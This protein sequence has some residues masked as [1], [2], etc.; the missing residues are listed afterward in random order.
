[1]S[2][3][4]PAVTA[5][6]GLLG[7]LCGPRG[8]LAGGVATVAAA[9]LI[10]GSLVA[11]EPAQAASAQPD[12]PGAALTSA[13]ATAPDPVSARIN[14]RVSG[15]RVEVLSERTSTTQLFVNPDGTV[16]SETASAPVRIKDESAKDGWRDI[17]LGLVAQPDGTFA[18]KAALTDVVVSG[19]GS[20]DELVTLTKSKNETVS[21]DWAGRLP[22]PTINGAVATYSEVAPDT[23][24]VVEATRFGFE[25]SFVIKQRP[26]DPA[27]LVLPL[28]IE[29][30]GVGAVDPNPSPTSG[31]LLQDADGDRVGMIS[32]ATTWDSSTDASGDPANVTTSELSLKQTGEGSSLRVR[33]DVAFL[34][35]PDTKYPVTV[36]PSFSVN[37]KDIV[38]DTY[39]RS[40]S[41][42]TKYASSVE[43]QV[44]TS[45]SG[46]AKSRSYVEFL[47]SKIQ[48]AKV[49][50]ATLKLYEWHS[51]SC[52]AAPL[53]LYASTNEDIGQMTWNTGQPT[54]VTSTKS[55][56][57]IAKGFSSDCDNGWITLDATPST[58]YLADDGRTKYTY[59][60]RAS[61]TSNSGW[62]KF[63]SSDGNDVPVLTVTYDRYPT[64]P[65]S[66]TSGSATSY[67]SVTYVSSSKPTLS[68]KTTDP[69]GQ[70]ARVAFEVWDGTSTSTNAKVSTCTSGYVAAGATASCTLGAALADNK[71]YYIRAQ[72]QS[73]YSSM[74]SSW[75]ALSSSAS[76]R[77]SLSAPAA[78]S[79]SCPSPYSNGSW[80]SSAPTANVS[81]TVKAATTGGTSAPSKLVVQV[82]N[83]T[84]T[85][86]TFAV[87]A[88]FTKT[89]SVSKSSGPH[90]ITATASSA[91]GTSQ[92]AQS[93][94][95]V[96]YGSAGMTAP[97]PGSTTTDLIRITASG[98][99]A[100]SA[101]ATARLEW[102]ASGTTSWTQGGSITGSAFN[103]GGGTGPVAVS[104]FAW[105]TQ[106]ATGGGINPR[107]PTLLDVRVCFDYA[108]SGVSTITKCTTDNNAAPLT[109]LRVP[110]A[111]GDGFPTAEAGE[112]QVALWTGELSLDATD[113]D[114]TALGGSLTV[115]RSHTSFADPDNVT[116]S[117]FGP[118]WTASFA[119]D[120][121]AAMQIGDS[122]TVDGTI[123]LL[124]DGE[125]PLVFRQPG[126]GVVKDKTGTYSPVGT[127]TETSGYRLALSGGGSGLRATLTQTDGSLAV[128][129]PLDPNASTVSW[130]PYSTT[131]AADHST[132]TY[133]RDAQGR[134]TRILAPVPAGV[135]CPA[136]GA[137]NPGCSALTI[138]YNPSG[139][140]APSGSSTGAYADRVAA[141]DYTTYDP[142]ATGGAMNTN[143][144]ASYAYDS[145]GRLAIVKDERLGLATTYSY[146]SYGSNTVVTRTAATGMAPFYYNYDYTNSVLRLKNVQRGPAD[147]GGTTSTLSAYVYNVPTTTS[148]LPDL[149][150]AKVAAWGQTRVPTVAFAVFGADHP[151]TTPT[152]S[153]IN[154]TDWPY[155][156]LSFTDADGYTTNSSQYGT[157]RWLTSAQFYDTDGTPTTSLDADDTAA[158]ASGQLDDPDAAKTITRYNGDIK[159]ADGTITV[160]AGSYVTDT[161]SPAVSANTGD[162][163][164]LVRVHTRYT[165][166]QG[167]PNNGINPATG[168][169]YQ[170]VT[171][172]TVGASDP[173]E[174]S[175]NPSDDLPPDLQITAVTKSGYDPIDGASATGA[176]SG[177]TLGN[178]TSTTVVMPDPA[179][180]I[181]RKTRYDAD[182]D[183]LETREPGSTGTDAG[184]TRTITYTAGTNSYDS[185]CG[186]KPQWAGLPCWSGPVAPP[187]TGVDIVD[188]RTTGYTRW[189]DP[190]GTL[191]TSGTGDSQATRTTTR[192]YLTDGRP[193]RTTITSSGITGST[194]LPATKTLYDST[195]KIPTGTANVDNSGQLTSIVTLSLD[196]W[197]RTK[198]Y[199]DVTGATT[200][201]T[202]VAPGTSGAGSIASIANSKGSTNYTYDGADATGKI[203]RRSL[204]TRLE[205]SG[206]GI[207]TGAYN[208]D[209]S[210]TTETMPA[211]LTQ[212]RTYDTIGRLTGTS[213]SGP[214]GTWLGYT[215]T[216]NS[217]GQADTDTDTTGRSA[218]YAYDRAG[219]LANVADTSTSP[220]GTASCTTRG[221]T[222]D[223]RG[224]RIRLT[225]NTSA[226]CAS[227]D[228]ALTWAYDSYSRQISGGG[229]AGPYAYDPFGRQTTIP[230]SDSASSGSADTA[231]SY[232]DNDAARTITQNGVTTTY[233][234]D[235]T[236]RR[237][238]A[239][240]GATTS[241]NSY[242]DSSDSPS[243]TA[244]SSGTISR[245]ATDL[246]GAFVAN[247]DITG[248][249]STSTLLL[250]ALTGA[251]E[252]TVTV[253]ASGDATGVTSYTT[254]DEYG[255]NGG[256]P[257]TGTNTYAW[258]GATG[259]QTSD[260]GLILMGA[261]LY[262]SATG[263]FSS[264]DAIAG[265][266]QNTYT[267]PADPI[268]WSDLTGLAPV[269]K[270]WIDQ[271]GSRINIRANI[272]EKLVL[273]HNLNP[274]IVRRLMQTYNG[275]K[276][277]EVVRG[278]VVPHNW[279]YFFRMAYVRDD[280]LSQLK[281]RLFGLAAAYTTI[282]VLVSFRP[283][284]DGLSFGIVTAYCLGSLRCPNWVN[285]TPQGR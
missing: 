239:A 116:S 229:G 77:T 23:D 247:I 224:N 42:D 132:T 48:G 50:S 134:V 235:P 98:P 153:G 135:T 226:S 100:G 165:Y 203:E 185:A 91:V 63:S 145:Q 164:Q 96:G 129:S 264:C 213:Y 188:T 94:Y 127:H 260:S 51:Y 212:V 4:R 32:P 82:D 283:A 265:A 89:V 122:T 259:R 205:V 85:T 24:L 97:K 108:S 19:G 101:T 285:R 179:D 184:T 29:G 223:S 244:S 56:L 14:A 120:T 68:A 11:A 45:N 125:D 28:S 1:M 54:I 33:P 209:G 201:T 6:L 99:P 133:S 157:G 241:T 35:D 257:M 158:A 20:D 170:L 112:G 255:R 147:S 131:E 248:S 83:A 218:I 172:T 191:E 59:A 154:A 53:D 227:G 278:K 166:D 8:R 123:A 3:R 276:G 113:V 167:A 267:Y 90:K 161:W 142:D 55:T 251:I 146:G 10:A 234:I 62:K 231:L 270:H 144:L 87:G 34:E 225:T 214:T 197:G 49:I 207:F 7:V 121:A 149:S 228:A 130:A 64:A 78:A 138:T 38:S 72:A 13:P 282:R 43:L 222:F 17:D 250:A 208:P 262:N 114:V 36:D 102:R 159:A 187:E 81:C 137:L 95:T 117:V 76:F 39:V 16:S 25:Q 12:A 269:A 58:Q 30:D 67:N 93:T 195:R 79:I 9:A 232:Y 73:S 128:W 220:D 107:R 52:T 109:V 284:P 237:I 41:P 92:G 80:T 206:L 182:G 192:T 111:F 279:E 275:V 31:M 240:S 110:H 243:Y 181:A 196:D 175:D 277:R 238:T 44:G 27:A 155:A 104:N 88:G 216:Y 71:T 74:N 160:P 57:N 253:P 236:G 141:I 183:T 202:Y 60:L 200:T 70:T 139:T 242:A 168:V 258:Q 211:G 193:D 65:S 105:S 156:D 271:W 37:T 15:H 18:P 124:M 190:T 177:W 254:Y 249:S 233:G 140:T 272:Y 198:T 215:R 217:A 148:G 261:R 230:G 246:T 40:D 266:N 256:G 118:G 245:Y 280:P 21:L 186:N 151:V 22:K 178:P 115:G 163:Q 189:L 143:R 210:L 26:A 66:I 162:D 194:A 5:R 268:N 174:Y 171:T 106:T 75:T 103:S 176:T 274:S 169:P 126:G 61:E 86:D 180:N 219:R 281:W 69:D 47:G 136:T 204:P 84:A 2:Y 221:Y 173:A 152:A 46:A 199:T 150:P 263:R 119:D 252:A 273:T